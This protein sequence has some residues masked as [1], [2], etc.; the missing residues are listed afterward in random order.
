VCGICSYELTPPEQIPRRDRKG[1]R[2]FRPLEEQELND[3][4]A[5]LDRLNDMTLSI[6]DRVA[7]VR[8]YSE[9]ASASF[10]VAAK[11]FVL[12]VR[13]GKRPET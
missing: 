7:A 6:A 2:P 11:R 1:S 10:A 9:A 5:T 3:E 4:Y 13:Q 12:K 8:A